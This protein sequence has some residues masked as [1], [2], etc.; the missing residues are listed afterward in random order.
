MKNK[1]IIKRKVKREYK[2]K[3]Y[4]Y[5]TYTC[6]VILDTSQHPLYCAIKLACVHTHTLPTVDMEKDNSKQRIF[7][8]LN[9]SITPF[10]LR[11][12]LSIEKI[13]MWTS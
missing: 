7:I 11:H 13:S 6:V 3:V 10:I 4:K 2:L 8:F 1:R 9:F 5:F 12:L